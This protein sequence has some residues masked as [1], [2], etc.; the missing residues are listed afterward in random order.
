MDNFSNEESS[1][2][3]INRGFSLLEKAFKTRGWQI[4]K[5]DF[6]HII[7]AKPEFETEHFEIRL[8][9]TE[10]HISVPVKNSKYQYS[11]SFNNYFDA[12]EYIEQHLI[13]FHV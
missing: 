12:S 3:L 8:T 13:L 5:N 4:V 9:K 7:Y 11:T 2:K 1:E 10:V 6:E